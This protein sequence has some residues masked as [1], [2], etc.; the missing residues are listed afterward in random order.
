MFIKENHVRLIEP[1]PLE[2]F[3]ST[4]NEINSIDW[5]SK[6]VQ[7]DFRKLNPVFSTSDTKHIRSPKL[8]FNSPKTREA[9]SDILEC[10]DS[11]SRYMYPWINKLIDWCYSAVN[12]KELG[13]IMVVKLFPGGRVMPHVDTGK[14]FQRYHR[15]HVPLITNN[16]VLFM[17]PSDTK[18]IHMP[19]GILCQ[20]MNRQLHG[21]ENNSN[22][23]RI[24]IIVDIDTDK[25]D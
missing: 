25:F 16:Q 1:V 15:F 17:G 13:R 10:K 6:S 20:L 19:T 2:L 9:M 7:S 4:K 21:V 18:P 12:G 14:Y 3:N 23:D 11:V 8:K 5:N 24:H 22:D